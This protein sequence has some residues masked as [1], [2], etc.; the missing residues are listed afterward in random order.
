MNAKTIAT[1]ACLSLAIALSGSTICRADQPMLGINGT[2]VSLPRDY[3]DLRG[4]R[5]DV[6]HRGS[7]AA[8]TGLEKGDIIVYVGGNMAFT[9]Y[10]AFRYALRQQGRTTKLGV[11]NVRTGRLIWAT[12]PLNHDPAPHYDEPFPPG[13]VMVDFARR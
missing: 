5:V 7:V 11:I 12:C 6:V 4:I 9:T 3:G 10:D 8:A 1:V 2:L 13:V